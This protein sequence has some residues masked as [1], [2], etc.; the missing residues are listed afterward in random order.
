MLDH[1][2]DSFNCVTLKLEDYS[3]TENQFL[4]ELVATIEVSRVNKRKLIWVT[5]QDALTR[6][7]PIFLKHGFTFH[8][9]RDSAT[10][11]VLKLQGNAYVPFSP[12]HTVGV[13]GFVYC[14]GQLL[15]VQ[16]HNT[17]SS[18][19]LPGGTV[20]LGEKIADA[21]IREVYEE[22]GVSCE[23]SSVLGFATRFPTNY[24]YTDIYFVCELTALSRDISI[25]DT[26]E[27][28]HASW[29]DIDHYLNGGHVSSFNR[30]VAE[31]SLE[32]LGLKKVSQDSYQDPFTKQEIYWSNA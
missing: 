30:H 19:K 5:L 2:V 8:S 4:I 15:C 28:K 31:M 22:T 18:P 3:A 12:T 11:L 21:V 14:D 20:D 29:V 27:I 1:T 32:K 6:F 7:I 25:T 10:R 13:G 23:F 24:G 17:S 16:G 26:E 9:C